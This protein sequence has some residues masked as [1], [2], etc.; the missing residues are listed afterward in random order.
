MDFAEVM[1]TNPPRLVILHQFGENKEDQF[2]WGIVGTIPILTLIGALTSAEV[3]IATE[4]TMQECFKQAFVIAFDRDNNPVYFVHPSIP[5]H[6]LL[7]MVSLIKAT[8]IGGRIAQQAANQRTTIVGVD[9]KPMS[10]SAV[11]GE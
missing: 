4:K 2:Q 11:K 7:G 10:L 1:K 5:K 8:V 9:G 6:S 3:M